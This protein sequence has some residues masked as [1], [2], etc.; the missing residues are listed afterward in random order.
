MCIRLHDSYI[1]MISLHTREKLLEEWSN[2][3]LKSSCFPNSICQVQT[4]FSQIYLS[5]SRI[6]LRMQEK[7]L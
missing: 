2:L 3:N 7:C 4:Q 1:I 6:V 5:F